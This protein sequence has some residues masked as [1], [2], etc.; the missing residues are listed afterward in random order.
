[1]NAIAQGIMWG[2]YLI[3]LFFAVFWLSVFLE[4]P[5]RKK[6]RKLT[7][8]PHVTVAVPAWN[9][10]DVI[11]GTMESVLGMSYPKDKLH[12]I[13]VNDGSTDNTKK[14]AE[15]V[16]AKHK[17]R[18]IVLINQKN[19]GKGAALNKALSHCKT[20]YFVVMDADSFIDEDAFE[21]ILPEF[22]EDVACVLPSMKVRNPE[23]ALQK[24]QW[25]EYILNMFYKEIMAKLDCVH[26]A[27]GPFSVYNTKILQGVGGFDEKNITEDLEIAIRL[28]KHN[29]RLKQILTTE[30]RTIAPDTL[31]GLYRQRKRWYKGSIVT[32]MKHK[33]MF[34]NQ[35][36]GDFGLIQMPTIVISGL[37]A[38]VSFVIMAFYTMKGNFEFMYNLSLINFDLM[39]LIK[40]FEFAFE[41]LAMDYMILVLGLIMLGISLAIFKLAHSTT[42]EKLFAYAGF[43]LAGYLFG[44]FFILCIVWVGVLYDVI[45]NFSDLTWTR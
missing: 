2:I 1:M 14:E 15:K 45:F 36:Y 24:M 18:N 8:Y 34:F 20:D 5:E 12:I 37:V 43:P 39:T 44:Y 10:E 19:A 41:P 23:N 17:G 32:S 35:D 31:K 16:I 29:Y 3:S 33:N 4:Q 6:K 9:E 42:S 26:V 7:E 27:P 13:V 25:Y 11:A 30:V 22:E 40:T 28:Q 21:H 38:I